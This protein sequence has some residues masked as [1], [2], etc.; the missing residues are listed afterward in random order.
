MIITQPNYVWRVR[1]LAVYLEHNANTES[2]ICPNMVLDCRNLELRP[3]V[4][5]ARSWL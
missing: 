3:S 5:A 2:R 1:A 4:Y